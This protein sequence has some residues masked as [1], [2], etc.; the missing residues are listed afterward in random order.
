MRPILAIAPLAAVLFLVGP[1]PHEA[2]VA[3]AKLWKR[4]LPADTAVVQQA[5]ES[6]PALAHQPG[7]RN[8]APAFTTAHN[9]AHDRTHDR[10]LDNPAF[11]ASL[12]H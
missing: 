11:E 12:K 10:A 2:N 6:A 1:T 8:V 5:K 4:I 7:L 9:R 3:L